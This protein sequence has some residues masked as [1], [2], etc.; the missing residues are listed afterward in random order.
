MRAHASTFSLATRLLPVERR[1]ATFALYGLFRTLDDLVDESD[2][3]ALGREQAACELRRWRT[4][5]ESLDVSPPT[6]PIVPAFLDTVHRYNIPTRYFVELI[7]GL[8]GDLEGRACADFAE[9]ALYCYRVASTVGLAMCSVLG[10]I[11]PGATGPAVEL[12]V[13]MQLT[14]VLRDVREDALRGHVY[15]PLDE[16]RAVGWSG[17]RLR[18]GSVDPPLRELI[19]RQVARARRYYRRGLAGVPLL[20]RDARLAILVAARAYAGI[21]DVIER[22]EYDVFA[23]RAR[24]ST[25]TKLLILAQAYLARGHAFRP[26]TSGT[27]LAPGMPAGAE[28]IAAVT[29]PRHAP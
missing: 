26:A 21:L 13:A 14:N 18:G 5:L 9:L 4:W 28:L 25:P 24:V 2:A 3:G 19:R 27:A 16:L 1:R 15:L 23:G 29:G 6:H 8:E 10:T 20:S 7:D 17:E 12:G 22:R 11:S